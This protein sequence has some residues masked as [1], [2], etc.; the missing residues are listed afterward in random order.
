MENS[1]I[2]ISFDEIIDK[3]KNIEFPD[4]D[5]IVCIG[6]G[7]IIPGSII[8]FILETDLKVLWINYRDENNDVKHENPK[9]MKE[10][11]EEIKNKTILLVD[12]VSRTGKTLKYAKSLLTNNEI[13]TLVVNGKAD[14]SLFNYD[15]C[16]D[17]PWKID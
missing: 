17:W 13:I 4:I 6:K 10:F 15:R 1:K 8:S 16:I 12:D 2:K 14:Y 9:L 7:G 3:I 11:N 5:L